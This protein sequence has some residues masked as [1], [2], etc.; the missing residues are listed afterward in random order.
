MPER[1]MNSVSTY[2]TAGEWNQ[3]MLSWWVEKP[4]VA[5]VDILWFTASNILIPLKY[6][7]RAQVT[8]R[9]RYKPHSHLAVVL[10]R[11]WIFP[12]F[13]PVV[14]A[15]KRRRSP[16]PMVG[17]TAIVK[18]TIPIPP[19][20]WVMLRQKSRPRGRLSMFVSTVA[21]V[22]VNPDIASRNAAEMRVTAPL[23]MNGSIPMAENISHVSDTIR[24]ASRRPI[25]LSALCPANLQMNAM[26]RLTPIGTV[27]A[28]RQLSP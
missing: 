3:A 18:N 23:K 2:S 11:G 14:S 20:Q 13:S 16:L 7:P 19:N 24:Q 8:V 26:R 27:N 15:E 6:S 28:V 21:P 1:N 17:S 4:P 25:L 9:Q 5:T 22:V 12:I 10:M